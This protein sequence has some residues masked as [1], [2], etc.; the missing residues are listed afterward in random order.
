MSRTILVVD[1]EIELREL[2]A[3]LLQRAGY[4]VQLA[5]HGNEAMAILEHQRPDLIISDIRMPVCDGYQLTKNLAKRV[6]PAIPILFMS[7]FMGDSDTE[8]RVYP[9]FAGFVSK[10]VRSRDLMNL[11]NSILEVRSNGS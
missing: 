3:L 8:L 5:G 1:D 10:P 4:T 6:G 7:G 2:L 9:G 11:V